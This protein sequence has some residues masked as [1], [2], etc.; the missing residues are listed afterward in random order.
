[1]WRKNHGF[2]VLYRSIT[3]CKI[4]FQFRNTQFMNKLSPA[5]IGADCTSRMTNIEQLFAI[6]QVHGFNVLASVIKDRFHIYSS[7]VF[8][9]F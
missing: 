5:E 1:M 7:Q 2:S 8:L 3:D 9:V 4:A 6:E